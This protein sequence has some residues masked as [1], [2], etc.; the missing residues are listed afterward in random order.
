[1]SEPVT[2]ATMS[3]QHESRY[4]HD[5]S[6]GRT[7]RILALVWSLVKTRRLLFLFGLLLVVISQIAGLVLPGTTAFIVDTII[8]RKQYNKL[9][10]VVGLVLMAMVVQSFA[11]LGREQILSKG[12][13]AL[14][15]ELRMRIQAHIIRLPVAFYEQYRV[16]ELVSRIMT[17]V[18]GIR[19]FI[20]AGLVQLL[21]G[22]ITA[23]LAFVVLLHINVR[24]TAITGVFMVIFIYSLARLL[25]TM[26]PVYKQRSQ[27]VA[28]ITGR[29]AES[30]G[31]VR[32]VKGFNAEAHEAEQFATHATEMSAIFVRVITGESILNLL[33]QLAASLLGVWVIYAGV[34]MEADG[35]LSLGNYMTYNL[36]LIYMIA[37]LPM[38]VIAG[39]QLIEA[40]VGIDRSLQV[41]RQERE[42]DQAQRRV[43]LGNIKGHIVFEH[44]SFAYEEGRPVLNDLSFVA[45]P[46]Q[47]L[48]LVGPSGAGK[49][50]IASLICAFYDPQS[51]RVTV[52]DINL[53]DMKLTSYRSQLG[54]VL[55]ENF[56]FCGS[57]R[58]NV[59]F[60]RLDAKDEEVLSA[61]RAACVDEF[62]EQLPN[63][64]ETVVG[65]RGV[66]LS[67][68]QRQRIS[69][70][71]AL[72]GN[73]RILILDEATSSL[74][75]VSEQLVQG[76]L[77]TL[78]LGRTTVVIAHRLS[79]I[80]RAD[81]ILFLKAGRILERGTHDELYARHS[82]YRRFFDQQYFLT[83]GNT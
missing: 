16:G 66:K 75:A 47:V 41:L 30:L 70:A 15:A 67:G 19:H 21:G 73:P 14:I 68:G 10:I 22:T 35:S 42:H 23:M 5:G 44:V 28:E 76:A 45:E 71:R 55:Q 69:I 25:A 56:L 64:Y 13:Y 33:S 62:A 59:A 50:T 38:S 80:R 1:M 78:M 31:G 7:R 27:T 2:A 58:E 11:S 37:P 32:V 77:A 49:S 63:K 74:D 34:H 12:G 48:A 29:L 4:R 81:Q 8:G 40:M 46:N 72:L 65:E 18:E 51:G 20:G 60:A 17:D 24:L 36:F 6:R 26:W 54:V 3:S 9:P 61:C 83:P 53:R 39:R 57:I 52:D 43:T 82:H 79:T